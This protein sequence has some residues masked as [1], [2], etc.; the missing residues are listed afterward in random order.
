MEA[1]LSLVTLSCKNIETT[2]KFYLSL[3]WK[4]TDFSKDKPH[5]Y[6]FT[7]ANGVLLALYPKEE[8]EKDIANAASFDGKGMTLAWN[9]HSAEEQDKMIETWQTNGGSTLR[10][11]FHTPWGGRVAYV[12]DPEGHIWE[13]THIEG[14][15]LTSTGNLP[16]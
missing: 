5:I 2:A 10:E 6:F 4:E 9:A 7:M 3:G 12:S 11:P 8:L 13:I 14:F 15:E 1:R 16:L